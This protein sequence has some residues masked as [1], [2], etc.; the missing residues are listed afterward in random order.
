[1]NFESW[2]GNM[3]F[4]SRRSLQ[5]FPQM[6]LQNRKMGTSKVITDQSAGCFA[7]LAMTI[8]IG[9]KRRLLRRF[10]P[11]NFYNC[12]ERFSVLRQSSYTNIIAVVIASEA[13]QPAF[14]F[15]SLITGL[16]YC[17]L[18]EVLFN[19]RK[20]ARTFWLLFLSLNV[21]LTLS[22]QSKSPDCWTSF[23][24]DPQLTGNSTA[25]ISTPLKLL[26]S[27]KTGDAIKS[28]A[29]ICK[30]II[31]IGS[32]DGYLYAINSAGQLKWKFNAKTSIE[33]AP[34]ILDN[35]IYVGSL[36]GAL[37]A[38]DA[39]TG[40]QKWKYI[41]DGQISG[42]CNWTTGH[43]K[44]QKQILTGSYDFNLHC[45]DALTGKG[46]WKFESENYINGAP[47]I[48]GKMAVFGG[49]DGFLHIVNID[50]GTSLT[51]MEI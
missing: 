31:Y 33:A 46:I 36:E 42:S 13:K 49:C 28:S 34:L 10:T 2:D 5:I 25:I 7:S 24:G 39:E 29:V 19:L 48:S 35:T 47:A 41:T 23:H 22:S 32:N 45:V 30:G 37:F 3:G 20:S 14:P 11:R 50:N 15:L 12:E 26:W 43:D 18:A 6:P 16:L 9:V 4:G 21:Q 8:I 44:K 27:Y 51:N 1:M 40:V 38:I 17:R